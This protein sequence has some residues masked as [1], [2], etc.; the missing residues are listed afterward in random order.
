MPIW[1]GLVLLA[2]FFNAIVALIDKFIVTSKKV[3]RPYLYAFY[4]SILS[5]FATVVLF[6]DFIP[7]PIEGVSIPSFSNIVL[8]GLLIIILSFISGY[9]FFGA[10][11]SMFTA[12]KDSDASDVVPVIGSISAI[13]TFV[14]SYLLLDSSLSIN[15]IWGFVFLVAGTFLVSRLRLEIATLGLSVLS[16]FFFS[17][18]FITIKYL[19]SVTDFDNG[20]FWSRIAIVI[21]ALSTLFLKQ[22]RHN[23]K[24]HT[25]Q[26]SKRGG[27]S[28][29][30]GNKVLAGLASIMIL[31]ATELGDVSIVQALGGLQF[32]FL[33]GFTAIWGN[34][35]PRAYGESAT[36]T[37]L[38]HKFLSVTIITIGFFLL[39]I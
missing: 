10:L 20:F 15:F 22:N 2:Q 4:V 32:V 27:I 23:L 8:P 36:T 29:I 26:T 5:S 25:Q 11:L 14:L 28:L 21:V 18:N 7:I 38:F 34:K 24:H 19:F 3:P 16:G 30:L 39:F 33:L 31:K 12:F 6:L 37:E 9:A 17:V 13:S 35:T 1:I